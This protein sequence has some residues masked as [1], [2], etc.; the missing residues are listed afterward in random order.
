MLM[1][2]M[3]NLLS[4]CQSS[5][6][7]FFVCEMVK[8]FMCQNILEACSVSTSRLIQVSIRKNFYGEFYF[9]FLKNFKMLVTVLRTDVVFY[10]IPWDVSSD[11]PRRIYP[12]CKSRDS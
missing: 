4:F 11:D 8:V 10:H 12:F 3:Q 7:L 2:T 5:K 6:D 1:L 9:N